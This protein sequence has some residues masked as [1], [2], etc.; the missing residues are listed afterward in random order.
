MRLSGILEL[1]KNVSHGV[2]NTF[3]Q[4]VMRKFYI[5]SAW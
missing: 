4:Q 1:T 3:S 5:I 2:L